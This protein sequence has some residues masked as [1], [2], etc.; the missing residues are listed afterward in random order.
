MANLILERITW[1]CPRSRNVAAN[2]KMECRSFKKYYVWDYHLIGMLHRYVT[3]GKMLGT[4][5]ETGP[6][7]TRR[8][9]S[10]PRLDGNDSLWSLPLQGSRNITVRS[11]ACSPLGRTR[12]RKP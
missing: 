12:S 4:D 1:A 9:C 8:A 11:M 5:W 6:A 7:G 3:C 10:P 2:V